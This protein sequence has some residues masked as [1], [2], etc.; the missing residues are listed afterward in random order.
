MESI[1]VQ[2]AEAVTAGDH[3]ALATMMNGANN[4]LYAA[5]R[6]RTEEFRQAGR[7][8]AYSIGTPVAAGTSTNVEIRW[9]G[10]GEP[11]C[12]TIQ[13]APD[14]TV[15]IVSDLYVCKGQ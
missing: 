4:I 6:G 11:M 9:T 15:S 8:Q 7:L 10:S 1:A 5:W 14:R 3:A 12:T 2:W 13:V